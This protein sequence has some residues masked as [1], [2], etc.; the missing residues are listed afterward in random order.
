MTA[1]AQGARLDIRVAPMEG[2]DAPLRIRWRLANLGGADLGV[3]ARLPDADPARSYAPDLFYIDVAAEI[4][5]LRKM[6]LPVPPGLQM[7][8]RQ[9]P[10]VVILR[11]GAAEE[12]SVL[13]SQPVRVWNPYRH[14]LMVGQS[15]GKPVAATLPHRVTELALSFGLFPLMPQERLLPLSPDRPE[16]LRLWPPGPAMQRQFVL[17]DHAP[18]PRAVIVLD[19]ET[20]PPPPRR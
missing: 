14:A 17:T 4:L 9:P 3:F 2:A 13:L 10:G 5:H 1:A 6:V 15:G 8:E 11:A 16:V 7:A 19:Y 12:G 20:Q 18:L